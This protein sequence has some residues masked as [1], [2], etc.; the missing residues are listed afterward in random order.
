MILSIPALK[1]RIHG[2]EQADAIERLG[3]HGVGKR[4]LFP[5]ARVTGYGQDRQIGEESSVG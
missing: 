2:R 4:G 1:Q 5:L 3:D